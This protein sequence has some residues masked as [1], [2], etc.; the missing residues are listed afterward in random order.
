MRGKRAKEIRRMVYGEYSP[1]LRGTK[2]L[3]NGMTG[4]SMRRLYQETK[5]TVTMM[6][7]KQLSV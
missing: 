5:R 3:P 4:D 7:A 1:R 2:K 6:G